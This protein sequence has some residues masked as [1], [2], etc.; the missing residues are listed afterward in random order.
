MTRRPFPLA[1][2]VPPELSSYILDFHWDLSL[3]R[4]LE[5]ATLSV[6]LGELVGHLDL[7]FWAY[8]GRPFQVTPHQVAAD[9]VVYR[10]QYDRTMAAD[11]S[12]PLDVV[13]RPDGLVTILDGIHRLLRAE[14]EGQTAVEVRVLP[15][16]LVDRISVRD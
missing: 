8:G 15:W 12:H 10:A 7:P 9:P 11:L 14:I 13:R 16:D 1:D 2:Q 6:P 5:L 3:L 4:Q